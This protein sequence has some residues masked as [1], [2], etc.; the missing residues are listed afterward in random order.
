[1]GER[2]VSCAFYRNRLTLLRRSVSLFGGRAGILGTA[3]HVFPF[4][5]AADHGTTNLP[6]WNLLLDP[7]R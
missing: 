2:V 7:S 4:A 6:L 1:M 3:G 5:A